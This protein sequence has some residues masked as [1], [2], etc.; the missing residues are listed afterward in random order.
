ML[1]AI[2]YILLFISIIALYTY[3]KKHKTYYLVD[4]ALISLWIFSIIFVVYVYRII[5]IEN[6]DSAAPF[7]IILAAL[8]ASTSMMKNIAET[9]ANEAIKYKK[10]EEK[11]DKE[12]DRKRIFTFK[13]METI[14]VTLGTFPKKAESQYLHTIG[15]RD[16]HSKPDIASDIQTIEKL[17][18]SVF[19]ESILPYLN[20]NEQIIIS[21]FYSEFHRFLALYKKEYNTSYSVVKSTNKSTLMELHKYIKAFSNFA[22]S[23]IDLNTKSK[24]MI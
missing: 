6:A 2:S 16:F 5:G 19:C 17:L 18:N 7:G 24:R 14:Q 11:A 10:D 20:D 4:F 8:L 21:T 15:L 23:Y 9:K 3:D 12:K 13:V 22:Q 1:E